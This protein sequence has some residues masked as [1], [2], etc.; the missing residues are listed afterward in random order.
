MGCSKIWR[1][2][3]ATPQT[4]DV[5]TSKNQGINEEAK[6]MSEAET[7]TEEETSEAEEAE[8]PEE[9]GT[10]V[11]EETAEEAAEIVTEEEKK[12]EEAAPEAE[13]EKGVAVEEEVK[14]PKREKEEEIVEER[15]YTIPLRRA[16]IMPRRKRTPRAMRIIRSFVTKHMKIGT[17]KTEEE[18]TD[19]EKEERLIISA[20]LNE[21]IWA[22]GIQKP[23]RR[24]KVRCVKDAEGAVTVYPVEGD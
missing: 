11:E 9:V 7:K 20:E 12:P 1:K 5:A 18:E 24:I 10:G 16:W 3:Q 22:R 8:E 14:K 21:K 23:P 2:V 6:I 15:F 19:E 4:E 13:A 17:T